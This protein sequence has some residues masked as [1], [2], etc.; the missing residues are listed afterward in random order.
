VNAWTIVAVVGWVAAVMTVGL[1]LVSMCLVVL[2]LGANVRYL[3]GEG[4]RRLLFPR[5]KLAAPVTIIVPAFNEA[6][7]IVATV[8]SLLQQTYSSLEIVVVDDGS[9]DGMFEAL[10]AAFDLVAVPYVEPAHAVPC[11]EILDV[12][13]NRC[14]FPLRVVRKRN[15]GKADAQN[16]GLNVSRTPYVCIVDADGVLARD[17]LDR[18][19]AV[20]AAD[21]EVV[22]VGAGLAV[23]NGCRVAD[24]DISS[25]GLPRSPLALMQVLEYLRGFLYGRIG[26]SRMN[27]TLIVS[28]A[29]GVFRRDALEA[30][31]GYR[32]T[33]LGEDLDVVLR[34][35]LD[36]AQSGRSAKI[37]FLPETLC[38]TEVPTD[39]RSLA[40]QRI[41]WA[42]GLAEALSTN[43]AI[44]SRDNGLM[45]RHAAAYYMLVELVS[46]IVEVAGVVILLAAAWLG[47]LSWTTFLL[48]LALM[49]ATSVLLTT[50][51]ILLDQLAFG[52]YRRP[53]QVVTL[54]A[55]AVLEQFGY[56]QINAWWRLRGLVRHMRGT[57]VTW[58][59]IQRNAS[60]QESAA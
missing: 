60:W 33:A 58:G 8:R 4:V 28:G 15:G 59:S 36:R 44:F 37:V 11:A 9:T 7:A 47:V 52:M 19:L 30:I 24:G 57:A 39:R 10:D 26:W 14:G 49:L 34:L 53:S 12:W 55:A 21:D 2:A 3:A 51:A 13:L 54:L 41:R 23:V 17:A 38:F 6:G 16:A 20:F 25:M 56:R 22:A 43:R 40:S 45:A 29:F 46:P 50:S 1:A 32:A 31:G 18:V 48:F 5:G 27:A 42:R 35:H